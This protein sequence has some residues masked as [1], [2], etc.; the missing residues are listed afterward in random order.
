MIDEH[1]DSGAIIE[2]LQH[3][4]RVSRIKHQILQKY[5]PPWAVILGSTNARL[6][7]VDCFAGPGM[8]EMDNEP[9]EGSPII[10]VREAIALIRGQRVKTLRLIL[11]DGDAAQVSRLEAGLLP[12][13]PY[14]SDL[15]VEVKC[16]DSKSF[17]PSLL[18]KLDRGIPAFFFVDP[19][20]HPLPLSILNAILTR[21]RREI[22]IN[23]M[24]SHI[25][26][27]LSNPKVAGRLDEL[28]GDHN[29]HSQPFMQLHF[30]ERER[31]FLEYFK[32][33][34]QSKYVLPFKIRHDVED[35][36][37]GSRTKYYLLHVSNHVKAALTMKEIMWPLGDEEGTF[38]YSG[39]SRGI[40][41]SQTPTAQ[42]L[43]EILLRDFKGKAV[44]FDDLRE[45]TWDLPFPEKIYRSALKSMEG[46]DVTIQRIDSRKTGLRGRDR[47]TF[48][49]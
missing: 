14:P 47:I 8:Y 35:S 48:R 27:D 11:V 23:L 12:F 44:G 39:E 46:I 26:R 31:A 32:S 42:Q 15:S 17:I 21:P 43:K 40:L 36:R 49:Q 20:G 24:W 5:F 16:A 29:W 34:L 4:K 18:Q 9:V 13:Q 2:E 28:F 7:Y 45:T 38:D 33:R 10:A 25:N 37:G 3:L 22:L 41:I 30:S 6:V 19:Y 1:E